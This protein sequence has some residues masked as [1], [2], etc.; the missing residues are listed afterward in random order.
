M[1]AAAD[2]AAEAAAEAEPP[3]AGAGPPRDAV[4][5][6][7]RAARG[8]TSTAFGGPLPGNPGGLRLVGHHAVSHGDGARRDNR[9]GGGGPAVVPGDRRPAHRGPGM[10]T[11][12]TAVGSV[13]VLGLRRL[14]GGAADGGRD[15]LGGADG[16]LDDRGADRRGRRCSG[17]PCGLRRRPAATPAGPAR[18]REPRRSAPSPS[19]PARLRPARPADRWP[20]RSLRSRTQKR[21]SRGDPP[22]C[23]PA[24][25][26]KNVLPVSTFSQLIP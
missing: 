13:V 18:R 22:A 24:E 23:R 12:G 7:R 9:L 19:P 17:R 2:P 21:T 6:A 15:G 1:A 3:E 20:L 14:R 5:P 25:R 10:G 16:G 4:E 11:A 8:A 26:G